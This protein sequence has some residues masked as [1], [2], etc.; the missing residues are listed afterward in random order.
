[1]TKEEIIALCKVGNIPYKCQY[2]RTGASVIAHIDIDGWST[3]AD[4]DVEG[5]EEESWNMLW[6][7]IAKHLEERQ[8]LETYRYHL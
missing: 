8:E 4:T 3:M 5:R 6:E 1:M 2:R 7:R